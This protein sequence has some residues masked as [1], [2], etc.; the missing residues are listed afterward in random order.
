MQLLL[1]EEITIYGNNIA[2]VLW[3]GGGAG[4][5][6]S[7]IHHGGVGGVP[8]YTI[9]NYNASTEF[10]VDGNNIAVVI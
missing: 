8:T 6:W 2:V 5:A 10:P 9:I 1:Q 7:G 4:V 3:W